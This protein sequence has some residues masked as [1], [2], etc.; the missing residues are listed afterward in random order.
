LQPAPPP[1]RR[2]PQTVR[3]RGA[4]DPHVVRPNFYARRAGVCGS[5]HYLLSMHRAR[6]QFPAIFRPP[7]ICINGRCSGVSGRQGSRVVDER[8]PTPRGAGARNTDG[9]EVGRESGKGRCRG[10]ATPRAQ[11]GPS[12]RP[13]QSPFSF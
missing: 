3:A 10:P 4:H 9:N 5:L 1:T 11:W 2:L 13:G 7:M 8:P 6:G 12:P